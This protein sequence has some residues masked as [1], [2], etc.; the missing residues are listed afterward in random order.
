MYSYSE[1]YQSYKEH[2][3]KLG[4]SSSHLVEKI[5]NGL[6]KQGEPTVK[7]LEDAIQRHYFRESLRF[8]QNNHPD[9]YQPDRDKTF[10]ILK[11]AERVGL[12]GRI[13]YK[14]NDNRQIDYFM[15]RKSNKWNY[16]V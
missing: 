6:R 12:I 15:Y 9:I 7:E 10:H 8:D 3:R 11:V 4:D 5:I 16:R 1:R 14:T 13:V 2:T